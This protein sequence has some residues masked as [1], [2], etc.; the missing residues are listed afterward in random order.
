M[1]AVGFD[2]AIGHRLAEGGHQS[3]ELARLGRRKEPVARK[4]DDQPIALGR[5]K[6]LQSLLA[7][8][9]HVEVVH[10]E[11]DGDVGVGIEAADELLAL[12]GKV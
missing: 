4:R 12:V 2:L 8:V 5:A 3:D 1:A 6:R 9:S 10:R 11:G 7:G